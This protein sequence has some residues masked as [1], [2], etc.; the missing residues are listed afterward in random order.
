MSVLT[1]TQLSGN[2]SS[3]GADDDSYYVLSTTNAGAQWAA[4]FR[5]LPSNIAS[6]TVTYKGHATANCTQNVNLW[7]WYYS[8]WVS[9]S[10]TPAGTSDSTLV[11]PAPGLLSDYVFLGEARASLQCFRTDSG[12]F[13]VHSNLL[14][15]TYTP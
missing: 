5:G 12:G 8:A 9:I 10:N 1:G 4:S 6:L 2:V 13:D 11:I 14:K 7:N 15:L 3:L